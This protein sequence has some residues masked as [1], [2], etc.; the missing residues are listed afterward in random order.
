MLPQILNY[1]ELAILSENFLDTLIH[2][3]THLK[4]AS[5]I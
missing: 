1:T 4:K 2:K 3:P 5:P